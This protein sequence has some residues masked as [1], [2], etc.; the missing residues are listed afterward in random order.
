MKARTQ[1]NKKKKKKK[2]GIK[3]RTQLVWSLTNSKVCVCSS[4]SSFSFAASSLAS[5]GEGFSRLISVASTEQSSFLRA[6]YL[7]VRK[8][9]ME[10]ESKSHTYAQN[11][12]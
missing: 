12:W 4:W 9:G 8:K 1:R 5:F 10:K 6:S 11:N 2:K 3:S 7:G